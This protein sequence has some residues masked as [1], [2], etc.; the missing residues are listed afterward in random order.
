MIRR[1]P[2]SILSDTLFPYTTLFRSDRASHRSR[3]LHA[4]RPL[5]SAARC[6]RTA[7]RLCRRPVLRDRGADGTGGRR[8][9]SSDLSLPSA[10]GEVRWPAGLAGSRR[11]LA[12]PPPSALLGRH[13][14][15]AERASTDKF[16]GSFTVPA[17]RRPHL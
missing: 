7:V 11:G 17:P 2:R 16:T 9:A 6:G 8:R 10:G 3:C 1:P 13:P 12:L 14:R 5:W 15:M 4:R